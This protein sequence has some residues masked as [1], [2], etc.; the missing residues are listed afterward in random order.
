[1]AIKDVLQALVDDTL[2]DCE[3]VG[4]SNYYWAFPSKAA[5]S[6]CDMLLIGHPY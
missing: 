5:A 4:S 1:M 2:V 6:V 3:K